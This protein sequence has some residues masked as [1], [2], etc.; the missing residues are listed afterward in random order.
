MT[1]G[2]WGHVCIFESLQPEVSRVE[3]LL[4][5]ECDPVDPWGDCRPQA[6]HGAGCTALAEILESGVCMLA[7]S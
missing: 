2:T 4:Y 5:R 3:D 6:W 7:C 1:A